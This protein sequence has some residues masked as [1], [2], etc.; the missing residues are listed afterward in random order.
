M[1]VRS[2]PVEYKGRN[3]KKSLDFTVRYLIEIDTKKYER[4]TLQQ[5]HTP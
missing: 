3:S 1:E 2:I 5:Q 4:A